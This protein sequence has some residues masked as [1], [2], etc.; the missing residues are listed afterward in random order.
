MSEAAIRHVVSPAD[1]ALVAALGARPIVLVG[2]MG[3]GKSTIGR[4][5]ATRL[6]LS[7]VDA[8]HGWIAGELMITD[9]GIDS[10]IGQAAVHRWELFA[11]AAGALI[12]VAV[13]YIRR[14]ADHEEKT[15][16]KPKQI[17]RKQS[18]PVARRVKPKTAAKARAKKKRC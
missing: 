1:A 15:A 2:M 11:A 4:R 10:F 3:A 18:A 13:G 5:L 17:A 16:P 14:R 12:V 6:G 8:D 7:F 9:P